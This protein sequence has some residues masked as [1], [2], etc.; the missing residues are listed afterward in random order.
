MRTIVGCGLLFAAAG[1]A[2]AATGCAGGGSTTQPSSAAERQAAILHDP[3]GYQPALGRDGAAGTAFNH[4]DRGS[5]GHD[6]HDL[7]DP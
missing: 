2:T 7:I 5:L 1:L 4:D 6:V 3:M